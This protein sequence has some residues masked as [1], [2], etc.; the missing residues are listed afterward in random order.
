MLAKE[1]RPGH[2][3]TRLTPPLSPAEAAE[4]AEAALRTTLAAA[5]ACSAQRLVLALDGAVGEW[6]GEGFE[7]IP[8]RGAGQA[9]RLGAAFADVPGPAVLIGMDS[10]QVS[11]ELIDLAFARLRRP[12]LDAVLGPAADGGWWAIG[13]RRPDPRVFHG[14]GMSSDDTGE[15]QLARLGELGFRTSLLPELRDVDTY[16]DALAVAEMIPET[17]FGRLVNRALVL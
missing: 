4:V 2:S 17:P 15:R 9:E 11:P 1:P 6:L 10:P 16:D 5:R 14:V 12:P 3:K 7:V 8:Q 13:M